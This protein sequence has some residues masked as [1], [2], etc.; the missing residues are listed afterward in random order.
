MNGLK[1]PLKKIR[2]YNNKT[3][4]LKINEDKNYTKLAQNVVQNCGFVV[5]LMTLDVL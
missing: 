4:I 3:W 2:E 1:E 5:T